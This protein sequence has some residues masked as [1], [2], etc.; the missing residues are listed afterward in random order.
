[1][2]AGALGLPLGMLTQR[3]KALQLQR[4]RKRAEELQEWLNR[5]EAEKKKQD[6]LLWSASRAD[7]E[8][9]SSELSA[10]HFSEGI[11]LLSRA[12]AY[13]PSNRAAQGASLA[14]TCGGDLPVW[15]L[16][17]IQRVGGAVRV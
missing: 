13:Q 1:M 3:D 5:V 8:A 4:E 16:R 11:A 10:A 2:I 7:H 17:F 12:L 15:L 9:A 6:G 14:F